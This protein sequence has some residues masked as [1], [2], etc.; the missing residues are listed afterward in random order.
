ML[1]CINI[2]LVNVQFDSILPDLSLAYRDIPIV[3]RTLWHFSPENNYRI[4]VNALK[5]KVNEVPSKYNA[6]VCISSHCCVHVNHDLS[7]IDITHK[8]DVGRLYISRAS[9]HTRVSNLCMHRTKLSIFLV[10]GSQ[11]SLLALNRATH[12]VPFLSHRT[13]SK[14]SPFESNPT[15]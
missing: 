5:Y 14:R 7:V 12:P 2:T 15:I 1:W 13:R 11:R 9:M 8:K 3:Y 10:L 6:Q 4:I